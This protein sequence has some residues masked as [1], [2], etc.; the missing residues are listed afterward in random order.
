MAKKKPIGLS[1]QVPAI[2][3]DIPDLHAAANPPK[4]GAGAGP[5]HKKSST[6]KA[7]AR[8]CRL[9]FEIRQYTLYALLLNISKGGCQVLKMGKFPLDL[10]NP[11]QSAHPPEE[12]LAALT[13]ATT[14]CL[15][16]FKPLPAHAAFLLL[17]GEGIAMMRLDK[18]EVPAQEL[19]DAIVWQLADKLSFSIEHSEL[20]HEAHDHYVLAAVVEK[21]YRDA[22]LKA[23][24]AAGIYPEIV[25]LLPFAYE[26]LNKKHSF[27]PARSIL[28]IDIS[29]EQSTLLIFQRGNLHSF[30]DVPLGEESILQAMQGVLIL[31]DKQVTVNYEEARALLAQFGLPTVDLMPNPEEP[32]LSQIS[33]RVRPIFEKIKSEIQ[34]S[35]GQFQRLSPADKI[36]EIWLAGKGVEIKG[37]DA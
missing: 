4:S 34:S 22:L 29:E 8:A 13:S 15:E 27:F 1:K 6:P 28:L 10:R 32:K 11:R 18:P 26:S 9:L 19:H 33:A 24:H 36:E 23:F 2:F 25:T 14:Q 16:A 7:R 12:I 17:R 5:K 21:A 20:I 31:D 30:R 37:M 35:L 3:E